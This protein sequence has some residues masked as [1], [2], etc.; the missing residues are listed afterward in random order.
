MLQW[1]EINNQFMMKESTLQ[2]LAGRDTD[3]FIINVTEI[4]T[5]IKA[6]GWWWG[7]SFGR[8]S[9]MWVWIM[10]AH[11]TGEIMNKSKNSFPSLRQ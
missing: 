10:D 5:R 9:H 1:R 4:E 2:K 7:V 8:T 11:I 3:G 6:V